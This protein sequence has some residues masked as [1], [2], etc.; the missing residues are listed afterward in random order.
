[1]R[2]EV[3]GDKAA[4]SALVPHPSPLTPNGFTL[5]EL[6]VVV[7]IIGIMATFFSLSMTGRALDDRLEN[8]ARRLHKTLGLGLEEAESKGIELGFRISVKG[9]EFLTRD[10]AGTWQ[11]YAETGPLRPREVPA[12]VAMELRVEGKLIPP[13]PERPAKNTDSKDEDKDR[14]PLLPQVYLLSSGELTP[15][16]VRI[17]ARG[18][19]SHYDIEGTALGGLT[20]ARKEQKP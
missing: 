13:G 3:K 19:P 9:Y 12:P 4:G 14:P 8:E 1:M 15:F 5:I 2:S 6:L 11:P 20:L 17:G 7:L 18:N 16:D 10:E